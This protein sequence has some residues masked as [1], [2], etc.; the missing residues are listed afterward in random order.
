MSLGTF[1]LLLTIIALGWSHIVTSRQLATTRK[2]LV[3]Y[4]YEYGHLVV[5]DPTRPHVM[6]YAKQQNPWKWHTNFPDGKSYKLMCGVGDIP[7]SGIPDI[8]RLNH[9][10]NTSITGTGQTKTL[11]VSL[12]EYDSDSLKFSIGCDGEQTV[13]QIVPTAD[14]YVE[15][16]FNSFTVGYGEAFAAEPDQPF[17]VFYQ[18]ERKSNPAGALPGVANGVIV[19]VE[20]VE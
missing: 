18:T 19:W 8:S 4:R 17:V 15:S 5:D 12:T 14:V 6:G 20:P 1:L 9:V 2:E 3:D 10:Q 13:S 11:F 7:V 16:V